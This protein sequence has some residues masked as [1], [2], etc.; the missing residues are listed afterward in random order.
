MLIQITNSLIFASLVM[1]V[2]W[3]IQYKTDNAG[4]VDVSWAF[5]TALIGI[6]FAYM[7]TD[8]LVLRLSLIH[9]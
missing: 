7:N 4:F 2:V 8:S 3:A 6:Y 5:C 1:F 9:I